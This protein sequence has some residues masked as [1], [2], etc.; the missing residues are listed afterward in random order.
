MSDSVPLIS[1]IMTSYNREKF[2]AV[3]I[4]S[5]LASTYTNFEFIICDDC[6]EDDTF[7]IEKKYAAKD[8]RIKIYRNEK[9]VGDFPNRDKAA[10][11][12]SGT[13]LKYVDS[14]DIIY[15]H[16]LQTM[17]DAM[18][19]FPD[20]VL[21]LSQIVNDINAVSKYP[22]MISSE[23]AYQEHFYGHG[24][25]RYGPTGAI[26]KKEV[27]L[28][29]GGFGN[30][31][32]VAD[33]AL[34]LKIVAKYPLV[35]IQ[36]DLV[37]WRRHN[38]QEFYFGMFH[39]FY[40]QKAYPVYLASLHATE[41]PLKK[42]DIKKIIKRLQWKHARDILSI[43]FKKGRFQHALQIFREAD[44]GFLQLLQG[45]WPYRKMKKKFYRSL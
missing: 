44:F 31:R 4:E 40:V 14:D 34:W 21:G 43:G 17:L 41:C 6:S 22:L 36:P 35:K 20:A 32:F 29:M 38:G 30:N 33:T 19:Q 39:D 27:L 5:I 25:L 3:A 16:G 7:E 15:P 13:Y 9:N 11:H 12:A 1:V 28:E 18:L 24:T 45:L 8:S 42:E 26:I 2:V 37:E 23:R 10:Y